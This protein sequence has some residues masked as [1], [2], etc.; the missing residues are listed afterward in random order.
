VRFRCSIFEASRG[1]ILARF[2]T[3]LAVGPFMLGK[4][5]CIPHPEES[6]LRYKG[7]YRRDFDR[8][9]DI[10]VYHRFDTDP[11]PGYSRLFSR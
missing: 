10:R 5:L 9:E 6:S 3:G 7:L 2:S 8:V 11:P 4:A 1:Q